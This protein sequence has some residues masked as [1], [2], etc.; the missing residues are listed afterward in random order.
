M[1]HH[2]FLQKSIP[3]AISFEL[4]LQRR[5]QTTHLFCEH[6]HFSVNF[7]LSYMFFFELVSYHE[8]LVIL[9]LQLKD[10]PSR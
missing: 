10:L 2:V 9:L 7:P 8:P 5:D 4:P 1:D 6:G 3:G